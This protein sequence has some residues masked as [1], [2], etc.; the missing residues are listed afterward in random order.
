MASW[1]FSGS[2][3]SPKVVKVKHS[4]TGNNYGSWSMLTPT[5]III[6]P[7]NDKTVQLRASFE[8]TKGLSDQSRVGFWVGVND[9]PNDEGN[10]NSMRWFS[11]AMLN[12]ETKTK[13]THLEYSGYD[14][15]IEQWSFGEEGSICFRKD[16]SD[17]SGNM[18]I[19]LIAR[20]Y[21]PPD[22]R[23][24]ILRLTMISEDAYGN[25]NTVEK[26]IKY[27]IDNHL[28]QGADDRAQILEE[29]GSL[30]LEGEGVSIHPKQ[31]H[32]A[33][34][35]IEA[36]GRIKNRRRKEKSG[37]TGI[38]IGYIGPDTTENLR[39]CI[40]HLHANKKVKSK[41]ITIHVA[42]TRDWDM[43]SAFLPYEGGTWDLEKSPIN[44]KFYDVDCTSDQEPDDQRLLPIDTC[45]E[46]DVVLATYVTSW[47]V[48]SNE[49]SR[50][51]YK[52]TIRRLVGGKTLFYTIEPKSSKQCV[53]AIP[54]T[55]G[56]D[57]TSTNDFYHYDLG[58]EN[59][60][61]ILWNRNSILKETQPE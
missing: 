37:R 42:C 9:R 5:Q 35:L 14:V 52:K 26:M 57:D 47:A 27:E 30:L 4:D 10:A 48:F 29:F 24:V 12:N 19:S 23:E 2:H 36:L 58:F 15:D 43:E 56:V 28:G 39:T 11:S 8:D 1:R 54:K 38:H 55:L 13:S 53:V 25:Q 22:T 59:P 45:P 46:L 6:E 60:M 41:N 40:R 32:S 61:P 34:V 17:A 7:A 16:S 49:K 20:P 3:D 50:A 18:L 51:S 31:L 44:L 21:F 33:Y